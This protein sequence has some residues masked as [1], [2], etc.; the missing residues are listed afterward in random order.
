M[1]GKRK[2]LEHHEQVA[3][4]KWLALQYPDQYASTYAVPNAARR[5]PRQ[6]AY[7]KAEGLKAGVPDICMA[8]PSNGWHGLYIELKTTKGKPT[9]SQSEWISRLEANGYAAE[10]CYG[11]DHAMRT[12]KD[13]LEK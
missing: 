8:Y 1:T 11:L 2:D 3:L 6:G 5:S 10:I 13:Y 12:I 7:M 4:F 9:K